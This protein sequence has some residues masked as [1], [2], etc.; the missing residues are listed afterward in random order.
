LPSDGCIDPDPQSSIGTPEIFVRINDVFSRTRGLFV[1]VNARTDFLLE[2][3]ATERISYS[4]HN[5]SDV[6]T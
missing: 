5:W 6:L 4:V 2:I 1:A 3:N